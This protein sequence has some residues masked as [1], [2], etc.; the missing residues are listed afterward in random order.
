MGCCSSSL[1]E[2]DKAALQDST[3]LDKVLVNKQEEDNKVIKLLL[4]G[5]GESGKSTIFKQMQILYVEE[6]FTDYEKSTFRHVVRRNVVEAMQTLVFGCE[7]FSITFKMGAPSDRAAKIVSSLDP[8]AADFWV[9]EIV[10]H[11]KHLWCSEPAI[12]TAYDLRSKMQLLDS[13][14]YLF[15]NLDRIGAPEYTPTRDDILR[16]RLRTSGIVERTF[17]IQN[18]DFKFLDVGGQRNERRKWIHCFE[19]VTAV[20]F[21]AA[22]S[23]YDQQLYED[24]KENRLHE[25]IRVFDNIINNKYFA[26]STIILFMNKMD[27]FSEKVQRVTLKLCFPEYNGDN[28]FNDASDYIRG[29]FLE[30]NRDEGRLIFPHLT[31]ATDTTNVSKVF[32]ACK[33]TILSKNLQKLGLTV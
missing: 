23:E 2:E 11:V 1:N 15:E 21:V 22:I 14:L 18:V 10:A 27:L 8:L 5:T 9:D 31:C 33:L 28:S 3:K 20:I 17:K 13:A 24:E 16:A 7:R 30:V 29:K 32:E 25:S 12:R 4:L 6:G 19:G 26:T